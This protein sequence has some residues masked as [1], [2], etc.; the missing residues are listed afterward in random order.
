MNT[1]KTIHWMAAVCHLS[2]TRIRASVL[3]MVSSLTVPL[4]RNSRF[5]L[6]A[7]GKL[8]R[9]GLVHFQKEYVHQQLSA[10]Q[11]A[12]R[13]CGICCNLLVTCPM[14]TNQG[15]CIVYGTCRPQACKTF[16]VDQRDIDE[17]KIC[18]GRCGFSFSRQALDNT[19]KTERT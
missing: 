18:S 5:M 8:R 14:L 17:V 19:R 10:R 3:F 6:H 1:T 11:G 16:P 12:C 9:F 15:K 2:Y 4:F 7:R 13:Q